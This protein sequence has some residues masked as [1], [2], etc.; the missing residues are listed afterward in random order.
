M[1][2]LKLQLAICLTLFYL[3]GSTSFSY[4]PIDYTGT[5]KTR[6]DSK[7]Q[8]LPQGVIKVKMLGQNRCVLSLIM[9]NG[10]PLLR[11]G[12]FFDTLILKNNIAEFRNAEIDSTCKIALRFNSKGISVKQFS[13]LGAYQCDFA[14]GVNADGFY[15]RVSSKAPDFKTPY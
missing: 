6:F 10:Q 4:K 14:S 2:I 7:N 8:T 15:F 11:S 9:Q 12:S 3:F 5:Y 13:K 1:T